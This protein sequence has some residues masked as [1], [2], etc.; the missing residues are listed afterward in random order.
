M[1]FADLLIDTATI[2]E[3]T[4][5]APDGY[6]HVIPVWTDVVGLV[7][8]DCRL[9]ATGGREIVVGAEV[10]VANYKLFM[11]DTI[12]AITERQRAR[13]D[14]IDYEILLVEDK[15]NSLT[16]HHKE[17]LMRVAR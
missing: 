9:M 17:C 14:S 7:D 13:I 16:S 5:A 2:L 10:V 15:Q 11:G 12:V 1:S 4:G 8:I 3:D 6:G